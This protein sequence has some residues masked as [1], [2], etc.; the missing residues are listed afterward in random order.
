MKLKNYKRVLADVYYVIPSSYRAYGTL[1]SFEVIG[2][3]N[4]EY[5]VGYWDDVYEAA[6]ESQEQLIDDIGV[7]EINRG[8]IEDNIDKGRVREYMEEFYRDDISDNPE[9]YFNDDDYQLTDEQ[10]E[11]KEQIGN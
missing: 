10:E 1:Y 4:Q 6:V 9:V 8:L 2:L 5:Y 7:D 11:R 3:R